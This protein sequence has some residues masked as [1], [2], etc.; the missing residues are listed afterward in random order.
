MLL[1]LLFNLL[2]QPLWLW[3]VIGAL[4]TW[5]LT[6][7]LHQEKIGKPLRSLMGIREMKGVGGEI[8]RTYPDNFL[9]QLFECFMCLSV[10]VG[11]LVVVLLFVFPIILLPFA[12]SMT[13]IALQ[14]L[15][16]ER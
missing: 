10:W 12:V 6:L 9:G 14:L 11:S 7:I 8:I 13:A 15:I 16:F 2:P 5:R 1:Q 3:L 4:A